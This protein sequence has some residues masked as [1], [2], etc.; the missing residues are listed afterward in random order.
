MSEEKAELIVGA[1]NL[2]ADS[3]AGEAIWISL[4]NATNAAQCAENAREAMQLLKESLMKSDEPE[5]QS[6]G[7]KHE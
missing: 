5:Q 4:G 2:I 1:V 7:G 6:N 3:R